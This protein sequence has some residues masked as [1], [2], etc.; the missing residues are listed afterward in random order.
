[1]NNLKSGEEIVREFFASIL[2]I[3]EMD[4]NDKSIAQSLK[5]LYDSGKF[6]EANV[7]NFLDKIIE[8]EVSK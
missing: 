7:K 2:E 6:T 3:P 5:E 1:M 8:Q 4:D